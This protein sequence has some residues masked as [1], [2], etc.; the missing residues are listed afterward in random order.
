MLGLNYKNLLIVLFVGVTLAL[1]RHHESKLFYDPF[2]LY[3]KN[4]TSVGPRPVINLLNWMFSISLRYTLNNGLFV[5]LIAV[6]FGKQNAKD[7]TLL[8]LIALIVLLIGI[9]FAHNTNQSN[10]TL[11]YLRRFL[12]QPYIGIIGVLTFIYL[13]TSRFN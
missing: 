10:F 11:F 13:R 1:I 7:F 5:I 2:L 6:F 12:I 3:F 8:S 4:S 9:Y